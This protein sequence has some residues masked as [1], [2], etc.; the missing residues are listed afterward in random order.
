V[1]RHVR[2]G[3][4][5][6]LLR[7]MARQR[8]ALTASAEMGKPTKTQQ[9]GD[10]RPWPEKM[11][12]SKV[13]QGDENPGFPKGCESRTRGGP[14]NRLKGLHW[15]P[16]CQRVEVRGGGGSPGHIRGKK[17][18]EVVDAKKAIASTSSDE[19]PQ[20][21][22]RGETGNRAPLAWREREK[23]KQGKRSLA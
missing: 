3:A 9:P 20:R 2:R 4:G 19:S 13:S 14:E 10:D 23:A 15:V 11:R 8:P 5:N 7:K 22:N 17:K 1:C 21:R 16:L 12:R 6:E 18:R